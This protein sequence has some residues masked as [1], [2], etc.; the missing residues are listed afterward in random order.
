[1]ESVRGWRVVGVCDWGVRSCDAGSRQVAIFARSSNPIRQKTDGTC[2]GH[3][4]AFLTILDLEEKCEAFFLVLE[5][6]SRRNISA[7]A[8]HVRV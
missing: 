1:V 8:R 4:C 5:N 2:R 7:C 6:T 3:F